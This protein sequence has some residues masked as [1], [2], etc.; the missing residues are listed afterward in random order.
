MTTAIR[1]ALGNLQQQTNIDLVCA[2]TPAY[3]LMLDSMLV[4][5]PDNRD[6]LLTGVQSFSAYAMALEECAGADDP[7][8]APITEKAKLYGLRL[9]SHYLPLHTEEN[10]ALLDQALAKLDRSDVADV[11]WG[12]FGWLTWVKGQQG[13]PEAIADMVEIEQIMTRLLALDESYQAGAIHL[14]FGTYYA[15]RPA[16][17]GGRPDLSKFHFE[18]ALRL[19][20]HRFL[21]TQ[22]TY[23]ETLARAT[24]DKELHD[25]LLNE[26]LGFPIAEAPEYGLSNQIAVHRARRLLQENYFD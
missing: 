19:A 24:F 3:L 14:F 20:K 10:G 15:A 23:A 21:L 18:K 26:V 17:L 13:S 16:M 7:Q 6:L 4:S 25:Q 12:T 9:L 2:G 11:F 1:P 22:T 8:I 5:S